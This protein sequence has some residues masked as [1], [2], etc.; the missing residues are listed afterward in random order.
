MLRSKNLHDRKISGVH[1][2][3]IITAILLIIPLQELTASVLV[4]PTVVFITD[5]NPTGRITLLNR[6]N[7]PQEVAVYFSFGLPVSDSLGNIS[8]TF[9]DSAVTDFYSLRQLDAGRP[10]P[11]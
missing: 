4:S 7:R 6:G 1:W 2:R 11:L 8:V 9:Q 3:F 10:V 5:K